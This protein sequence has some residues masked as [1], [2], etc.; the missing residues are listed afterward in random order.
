MSNR[1]K[2]Q[3]KMNV[4]FLAIFASMVDDALPPHHLFEIFFEP[5]NSETFFRT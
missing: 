3:R 5:S 1:M 4:N 2:T